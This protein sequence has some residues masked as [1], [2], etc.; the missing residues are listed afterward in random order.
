MKAWSVT[1][2]G[3]PNEVMVLGERDAPEPGPGEVQVQVAAAGLGLPDVFMCRGSYAFS[4]TLPFTPGQE[5]VGVV[6]KLGENSVASIGQRLMGVTSFYV[7]NGGYAEYCIVSDRTSYPVPKAMGDAEA[8]AFSIPFHTA[9]VGLKFRAHMQAG[10]TLVVHGAAGG[11]GTAAV[12]LGKALGARVM[13]TVSTPEKGD[14]CR[15]LGADEVIDNT[16]EDFVAKV[17]EL[18]DGRGADVIYDPVGGDTCERSVTCTASQGRILAVGFASG[19]W[20]APATDRMVMRNCSLLGVFV[21]AYN[22]DQMLTAHHEL[23][24]L[25]A[26]G[27][28]TAVP[29]TTVGF[30]AVAEELTRLERREAKGKTVALVAP[31]TPA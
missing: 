25:H 29:E 26:Q 12:Q 16:R 22:H 14:L 2:V 23:L 21:G 1:G 5:V 8:A 19:R 28:L 11:T 18:T 6:S 31:H 27:L 7:G 24:Q 3:S 17:L 9:W 30:D 10:E 15:S 4:P 20:G 13:A